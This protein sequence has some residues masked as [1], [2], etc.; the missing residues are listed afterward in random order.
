[1]T[2]NYQETTKIQVQS[3]SNLSERR[4]LQELNYFTA[5]FFISAEEESLFIFLCDRREA[6]KT[7]RHQSLR[8]HFTSRIRCDKNVKKL[9]KENYFGLINFFVQQLALFGPLRNAGP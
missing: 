7:Q 6:E 8:R 5:F 9:D 1:M 4:W 3:C 2:T